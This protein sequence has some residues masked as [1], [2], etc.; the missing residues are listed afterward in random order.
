M[1]GLSVKESSATY[2]SS[3]GIS[4]T[5]RVSLIKRLRSGFDYKTV[6]SVRATLGVPLSELSQIINIAPRTLS[7]RKK[8]GKL[9]TDESERLYRVAMLIERATEVLEDKA[10]AI[11]W[12]KSPKRALDGKTPLDFSDT[13]VGIEEVKELLGRI[14]HGVFA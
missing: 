5:S 10:T 2:Q 1:H 11:H 13:E 4:S 7:R 8:E 3:V 12:L 14:E 9:H 6:E